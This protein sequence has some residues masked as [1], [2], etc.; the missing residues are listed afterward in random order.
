MER[1][2]INQPVAKGMPKVDK[3]DIFISFFTPGKENAIERR[4]LVEM[5]VNA[6]LIK[7]SEDWGNMDRAMRKLIARVK[8][9]YNMQITNDGDGEGYYIPTMKESVQLARNN[10]RED[11][12]AVTTFRNNKSNKALA[13]DYKH[14]RMGGE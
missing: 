1:F 3:I 9:D 14:G 5:C 7:Y 11:K 12:R 10:K 2:Y 4:K 6:G 8:V 13:E